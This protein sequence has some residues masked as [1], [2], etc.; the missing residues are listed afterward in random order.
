MNFHAGISHVA[1]VYRRY[2][3][4]AANRY[5]P[6]ISKNDRNKIAN[7]VHRGITLEDGQLYMQLRKQ[8]M[9]GFGLTD[10]EIASLSGMFPHV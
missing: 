4:D 1:S 3:A 6:G 8:D 5:A 9:S 2:L 7:R 10:E